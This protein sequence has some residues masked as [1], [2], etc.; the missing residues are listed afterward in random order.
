MG[1]VTSAVFLF[2]TLA[3]RHIFAQDHGEEYSETMGPVAFMWPPDR[4]WGAAQDNTAPCGSAAAVV[5]RTEFPLRRW[6]SHP[7]GYACLFVPVNGQIAL[8]AQD[9]SWSIQVAISHR[10]G[11]QTRASQAF[12]SSALTQPSDPSSNDDFETVIPAM[13][14]PELNEGHMCYPIPNP[15]AD[16]E[17]F[18]NATLQIRYT[19]DFEDD[20]NETYYACADITYVPTSQFTYQVP[21]FN[22]TVEDFEISDADPEPSSSDTAPGSSVT[23]GAIE[24]TEESSGGLSKGAI[25]G[26]VVGVVVG[27]AA[28][29]GALIYMWRRSQQ[30]RR[31]RQQEAS[32]RNVKWDDH[33][34]ENNSASQISDRD[35]QLRKL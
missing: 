13:R 22:A 29:L 4:E 20:K 12:L 24:A 30:K 25:A 16:I 31:L 11:K 21:C 28:F 27:V 7:E 34:Q 14:I 33:V 2:F 8:V 9:E 15:S 19:S 26:I 35:I 32:L 10:N 5:N 1:T 6:Q 18:S 17:A 3:A 23:S